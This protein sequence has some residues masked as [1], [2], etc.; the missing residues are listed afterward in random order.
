MDVFEAIKN[1]R[2]IRK[3]KTDPIDE[4]SLQKILEAARW[5][6][7]WANTQTWR[8]IVVRDGSVK[9]RLAGTLRSGNPATDA[10]RNSPVTIVICAEKNRAGYK[11]GKPETNKGDYWYMFDAG[12]AMQNICL[13]AHA[14]GL[15]TVIVG[16]F[17][18]G[19]AD[20]IL[21]VPEG[22]C[23]VAMTPL[24]LPAQEGRAPAR[25]ELPEIVYKDRFG[26]R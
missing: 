19:A 20:E 8:F 22:Y 26:A 11:D 6:P 10:V 21:E 18:A 9:D 17:N 4:D 15:G 12:V 24:G 3:Q 16:A 2:S 1:R 5:A 25:K 14:L 23:T 7:S 13:A